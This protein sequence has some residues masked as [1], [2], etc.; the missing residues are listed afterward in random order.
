M[1]VEAVNRT[2]LAD[3][4]RTVAGQIAAMIRPLSDTG[5]PIPSSDW[6][7]G[8]AGAHLAI[9][10]G[11]FRE[12]AEGTAI[13]PYE[14]GRLE[15]FAEVN[16]RSLAGYAERHGPT[17][18]NLIVERTHSALEAAARYPDTYRIETHF[19][20]MDVLTGS[21]YMLAHLLMHGCP[22]ADALGHPHP[23]KPAHVELALPF[24]KMA[25][26]QFFDRKAAAALKATFAIHLRGGARFA[27]ICN[28]GDVRVEDDLPK[29][30]DVH[31]SANPVTFFYVGTGLVSQWG[32]IAK[33][34]MIAWGRK[35]WLAFR[36]KS[37]IPTP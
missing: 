33:G 17:L 21:S 32:P 4:I 15:V 10:Q 30:V 13:S 29:R 20:P 2:Q 16:A 25:I 14:D 18:A 22:I 7:V 19:G 5:V 12:I 27:V 28:R 26:V 24:F 6:T 34:K 35:P 3:E 31:I 36:F 23:I 1:A 11:L 37:L 9:T 8:E